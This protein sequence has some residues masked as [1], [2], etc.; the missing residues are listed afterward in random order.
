MLEEFRRR[1][2]MKDYYELKRKHEDMMD[3]ANARDAKKDRIDD[4]TSTLFNSVG[5]ERYFE[6]EKKENYDASKFTLIFLD[7]DS[8][9]NVTSLNRVN[10]RRVLIFCGNTRGKI[11]FGKGKGEDYE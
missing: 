5:P 7:S 1:K 6:L 4:D 11:A 10:H 2:S 8:V 3:P 9:T